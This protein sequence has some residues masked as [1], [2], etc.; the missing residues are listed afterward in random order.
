MVEDCIFDQIFYEFIIHFASFSVIISN[1]PVKRR[2]RL[3]FTI[4]QSN[5]SP[6][7]LPFH[8]NSTDYCTTNLLLFPPFLSLQD[9][10]IFIRQ[11]LISQFTFFPVQIY[12]LFFVTVQNI[13][14]YYDRIKSKLCGTENIDISFGFIRSVFFN[15]MFYL[16]FDVWCIILINNST[17]SYIFYF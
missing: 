15:Y 4:N 9:S 13:Y 2:L 3:R 6:I 7:Q 16:L 8:Y 5:L 12:Q 1:T 11:Q 10:K 17:N 14:D